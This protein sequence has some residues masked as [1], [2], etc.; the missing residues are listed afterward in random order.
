MYKGFPDKRTTVGATMPRSAPDDSTS[1]RKTLTR[2]FRIAKD[3]TI[4]DIL[5]L[6]ESEEAFARD[7]G[8]VRCD[9]DAHSLV[10]IPGRTSPPK[11]GAR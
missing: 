2:R 11:L 8:P 7:Q 10:P 4:G 3:S 9:V 6:A 5:H 1:G